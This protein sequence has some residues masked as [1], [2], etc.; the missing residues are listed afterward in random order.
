MGGHELIRVSH[1]EEWSDS[2]QN[3][4]LGSNSVYFFV[5]FQA[6]ILELVLIFF[7][8][9]AKFYHTTSNLLII[10]I[11][12][13]PRSGKFWSLR[14]IKQLEILYKMIEMVLISIVLLYRC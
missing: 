11:D 14:S 8:L 1:L 5:N 9:R 12:V 6:R 13:W 7:A 2:L 3:L 10:I 4:K